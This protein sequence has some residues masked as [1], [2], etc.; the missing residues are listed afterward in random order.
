MGEWNKENLKQGKEMNDA[1]PGLQRHVSVS[2]RLEPRLCSVAQ[3]TCVTERFITHYSD[4]DTHQQVKL[5]YLQM[6]Q[7]LEPFSTNTSQGYGR[8]PVC[9]C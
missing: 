6:F 8:S 1:E 3:A 9:T 5:M 7:F 2:E 4:M